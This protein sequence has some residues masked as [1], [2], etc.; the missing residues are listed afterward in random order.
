MGVSGA[1]SAQDRRAVS[2]SVGSVQGSVARDWA[3]E[4]ML[5]APIPR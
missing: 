4:Q 3:A 1:A 2:A 5:L